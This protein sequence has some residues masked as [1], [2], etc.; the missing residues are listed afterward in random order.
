MVAN[1]AQCEHFQAVV[2]QFRDSITRDTTKE[3]VEQLLLP[4]IKQAGSSE[5]QDKFIDDNFDEIW[6]LLTSDQ[7]SYQICVAMGLCPQ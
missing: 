7:D 3:D 5:N 1:D 4:A 6:P 2:Q